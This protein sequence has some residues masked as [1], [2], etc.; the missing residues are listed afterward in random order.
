MYWF[1]KLPSLQTWHL[2][3]RRGY[4]LHVAIMASSTHEPQFWRFHDVSLLPSQYSDAHSSGTSPSH[5][6][7][8][9]GG[10]GSGGG[11]VNFRS[12]EELSRSARQA[13]MDVEPHNPHIAK[14][15]SLIRSSRENAT[16]S[17][18][19]SPQP[20]SGASPTPSP[21]NSLHRWEREGERK[22]LSLLVYW[23]NDVM[24]IA[25]WS[26]PASHTLPLQT[27]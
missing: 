27:S 3:W 16:F 19:R 26:I 24:L 1:Q 22:T 7:G 2:E 14:V 5:Q 10:G 23:L 4:T 21:L 11:H 8:G 17:G 18:Q 6:V 9:G 15:I 13:D 12:V 20:G 25:S